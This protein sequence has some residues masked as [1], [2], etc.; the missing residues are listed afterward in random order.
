MKTRYISALIT[1][2]AGAVAAITGA[3]CHMPSGVFIRCILA[4]L[5]VFLIIG[6]MVEKLIMA[7]IAPDASR[8]E[9]EHFDNI[10]EVI[11]KEEEYDVKYNNGKKTKNKS[12]VKRIPLS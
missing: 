1:L 3:I 5:V 9:E 12:E 8:D 4:T 7:T 2:G 6:L 11:R 10:E